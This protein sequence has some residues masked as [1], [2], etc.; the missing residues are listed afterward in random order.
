M[1]GVSQ[2]TW[3]EIRDSVRKLCADFPGAYWRALALPYPES[4]GHLQGDLYVR[5]ATLGCEGSAP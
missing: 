2:E 5:K 3:P 1:T 4:M